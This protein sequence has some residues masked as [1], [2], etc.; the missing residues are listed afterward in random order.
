MFGPNPNGNDKV[1]VWIDASRYRKRPLKRKAL[2]QAIDIPAAVYKTIT[3]PALEKQYRKDHRDYL[4]AKRKFE[5]CSLTG[6]EASETKAAKAIY[7][8]AKSDWQK[9]TREIYYPEVTVQYDDSG[10]P[11]VRFSS[12]GTPFD[13]FDVTHCASMRRTDRDVSLSKLKTITADGKRSGRREDRCTV[14]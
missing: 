6:V 13:D 12:R 10:K 4:E 7:E 1:W 9:A 14:S 3:V 11:S 8:Q 2:Q 5:E